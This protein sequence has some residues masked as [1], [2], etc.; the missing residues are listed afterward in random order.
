[1]RLLTRVRALPKP[2]PLIRKR[3]ILAEA[4][5]EVHALMELMKSKGMDTEGIERDCNRIHLRLLKT[6]IMCER[7]DLD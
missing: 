4:F 6:Q 1:M 2:H 3:K 7:F 5:S